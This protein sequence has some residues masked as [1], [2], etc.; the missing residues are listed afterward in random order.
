MT[1]ALSVPVLP[2]DPSEALVPALRGRVRLR[3]LTALERWQSDRV[4]T[5]I[6]SAW[7]VARAVID[8]TGQRV[9]ADED[10]EWLSLLPADVL[11]PMAD[12]IRTAN[13]LDS[14]SVE[15]I[16]EAFDG[17]EEARF[18]HR[19]ALALSCPSVAL[20]RASMTSRDWIRWQAYFAAEPFGSPREDFRA[21]YAMAQ[22]ANL[23]RDVKKRSQPY[24]PDDFYP[25]LARE[26][27]EE[28][29]AARFRE[30]LFRDMPMRMGARG[31]EVNLD[32]VPVEFLSPAHRAARLSAGPAGGAEAS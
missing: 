23:H 3:E 15:A 32:E 28:E 7:L 31:A 20:L 6:A 4:P 5:P 11:G 16:L 30:T 9:Y 29:K 24:Q 13:A 19:L 14:D 12:A 8:D 27:T 17:D 22:V 10:L 21:A 26:E 18:A 25:G 2:A 1:P